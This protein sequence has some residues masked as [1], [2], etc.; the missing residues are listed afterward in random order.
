MTPERARE[1]LEKLGREESRL[2]FKASRKLRFKAAA[3]H[4]D[5]RLALEMGRQAIGAKK[6]PAG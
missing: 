1:I 4:D 5:K 2:A 3:M 6:I